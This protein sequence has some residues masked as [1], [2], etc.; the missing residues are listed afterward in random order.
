[1]AHAPEHD[2]TYAVGGA[3]AT[4]VASLARNPSGPLKAAAPHSSG[5]AHSVCVHSP[6][7][8]NYP[9]PPQALLDRQI[10]QRGKGKPLRQA[11]PKGNCAMSRG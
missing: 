8:Q 10:A 4:R 7:S 3:T 6:S 5:A 2:I 11:T 1:M 9:S